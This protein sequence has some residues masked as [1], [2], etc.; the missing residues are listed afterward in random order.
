M[1]FGHKEILDGSYKIL[2]LSYSLILIIWISIFEHGFEKLEKFKKIFSLQ[3]LFLDFKL[4]TF[5]KKNPWIWN[6][7][8]WTFGFYRQGIKKG[9]TK[10]K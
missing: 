6:L 8:R 1:G 9:D 5:T 4:G 2:N 3:T 10:K 7:Y